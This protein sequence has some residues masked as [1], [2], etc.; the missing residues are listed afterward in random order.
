[1]PLTKR[2]EPIDPRHPNTVAL[3]CGP[4]VLFAVTD[5]APAVTR[6]QLLSARKLGEENWQVE[7]AA[8][9]LKMLPFTAISDE[10]YSAYLLVN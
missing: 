6:R 1:L 9:P 10:P 8:A 3:L 4:L 2:L 5:S 7:T